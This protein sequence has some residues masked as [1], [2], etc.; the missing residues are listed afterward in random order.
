[1]KE[2]IKEASS[3]NDINYIHIFKGIGRVRVTGEELDDNKSLHSYGYIG[4][5]NLGVKLWDPK[6]PPKIEEP[7]PAPSPPRFHHRPGFKAV[8]VL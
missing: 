2:L 7:S 5:A 3:I 4:S 1:M 6:N 8:R